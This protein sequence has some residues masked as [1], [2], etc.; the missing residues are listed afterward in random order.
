M[1]WLVP[2]NWSSLNV[3]V[4]R[5]RQRLMTVSDLIN[6]YWGSYRIHIFVF[7]KVLQ[8]FGPDLDIIFFIINYFLVCIFQ[9]R[10]NLRVNYG[11]EN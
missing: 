3:R 2:T 9:Y 1:A 8:I 11:L 6:I 10:T 7:L 5:D 4:L